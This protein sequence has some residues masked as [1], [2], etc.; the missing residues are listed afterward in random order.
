ME[1]CHTTK[2]TI[3]LPY[4]FTFFAVD[5]ID[6]KLILCGADT[7]RETVYEHF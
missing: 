6:E 1:S 5:I 2:K 4:I 7:A 3:I